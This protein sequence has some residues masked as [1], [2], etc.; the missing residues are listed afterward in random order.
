MQFLVYTQQLLKEI[1]DARHVDCWTAI[2]NFQLKG[3]SINTTDEN[4]VYFQIGKRPLD[5]VYQTHATVISSEHKYHFTCWL[6]I[7]NLIRL[8][9]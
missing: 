1:N 5:G 4:G 6:I 2:F 3:Q 8:F 9:V 7:N